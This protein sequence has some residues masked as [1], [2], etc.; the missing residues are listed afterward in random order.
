MA[1]TDDFLKS[2]RHLMKNLPE[3]LTLAQLEW[4]LHETSLTLQAKIAAIHATR[5]L[6]KPVPHRHH[7][8]GSGTR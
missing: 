5:Q 6:K 7:T 4:A 3:G 8:Q 2:L 1:E